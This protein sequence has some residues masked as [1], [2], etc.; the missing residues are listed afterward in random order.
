MKTKIYPS[1]DAIVADIPDGATIMFGGFGG[2]GF[3]NNLIQALARKGTKNIAAISN[4]CGT[5]EGELGL[6]FKNGQVRH[7]IAS[8]PG[9]HANYFQERYA[10]KEVTLELVP[11]GI[12]CERMRAA[13]AGLLGFYTTVGV[14]TEVAI[15]KEERKLNGKRC[16]LEM[17]LHADYAF[18]KAHKADALGN[19][20]YRLAARNFNPIMAMAAKMTIVETDEIVPVGAIEPENVITP[21]IFVH[22]IVQ[23]KGLR[24]AG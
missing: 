1:L 12:L 18:I 5:R 24:Y 2:A 15:G 19:L 7:V 6:M 21:S 11:Q 13:A 16:I 17:A 23:A 8:F 9:P 3:P 10:A 20:T 14:G 4:N 22:R